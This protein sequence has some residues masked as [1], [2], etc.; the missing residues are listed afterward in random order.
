ME[1][2]PAAGRPVFF[3]DISGFC[4]FGCAVFWDDENCSERLCAEERQL[5]LLSMFSPGESS[6]LKVS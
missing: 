3:S 1:N 4:R 6:E 2:H 5:M